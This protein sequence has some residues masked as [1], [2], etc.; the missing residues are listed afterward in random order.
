MGNFTGQKIKDTY[1]RVLQ[2]NTGSILDGLG[3]SVDIP[4]NQLSGSTLLS[5][6]TQIASEISGSFTAASASLATDKADKG[7]IS[8]SFTITSASLA[9][10]KA[11]KSSISGSFDILSASLQSRVASQESFSSSLDSTF[12]TDA[13]VTAAVSAL[14]ILTASLASTGSNTLTGKQTISAS[15]AMT[16]SL[17]VYSGKVSI[18]RTQNRYSLRS[19]GSGRDGVV[20]VQTDTND[21]TVA[22]IYGDEVQ[23][24]VFNSNVVRLGNTESIVRM[25]GTTFEI[26]ASSLLISSSTTVA[27]PV[28]VNPQTLF[29]LSPSHPLPGSAITGS[30]AVTGSTLAFYDGN[31]W[32]TV[33]TGSNLPL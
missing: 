13:S 31:N 27:K 20:S 33:T 24:G 7:S 30:F 23:V 14:N 29:S 25:D 6:S 10:D 16:G 26:S 9:T 5:G 4:T 8:G 22:K 15:I 2:L 18:R 11:D 17:N 1:I 32:V 19:Q 28:T 3:N 21:A 12:A